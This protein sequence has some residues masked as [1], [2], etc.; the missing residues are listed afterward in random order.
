MPIRTDIPITPARL[1]SA[2]AE[3]TAA[4]G[5]ISCAEIGRSHLN[6]PIHA[7]TLGRGKKNV[8]I[9]AAHHANEWITTLILMRFLEELAEG[10]ASRR[11]PRWAENVT[12]HCIPLVNP[13]G[14]EMVV[15]KNFSDWKANFVGV[16][17]N[18]NYPAGWQLARKNKFARGFDK[19]GPRDFVGE[20][21]LSEPESA[22]LAV[23]TTLHD[24]DI[25]ISLHTQGEEIYW[26][27]GDS[28]PPGA[29][30]LARRFAA[31]SGYALE[32]V[33]DESS[34]AGYRDWFIATF[35]RPG[36]TIECGLGENP[37][38]LSQFDDMYEKA[39]AILLEAIA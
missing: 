37:L 31:A 8:L 28:D 14:V 13:D 6:R 38:P 29:E 7:L 16:D 35:G 30:K 26:R 2:V 15:T 39:S 27:Y 21:P 33:P 12:L 3:L 22:A 24:I 36:F 4:C 25:T 5:E 10:F 11:P 19:P 34:H 23:Y 17:L 18:S 32:E 1:A 9:N 20:K